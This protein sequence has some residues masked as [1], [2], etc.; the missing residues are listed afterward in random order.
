MPLK[1]KE[2]RG[3]ALRISHIVRGRRAKG[4][5]V[6]YFVDP[7]GRGERRAIPERVVLMRWRKRGN[8]FAG[9]R[10]SSTLW[11]ALPVVLGR[12]AAKWHAH[13]AAAI[14]RKLAA[15][16]NE[17]RDLG[18]QGRP[19]SAVRALLDVLSA[20]LLRTLVKRH[21]SLVDERRSG[22]PDLFLYRRDTEGRTTSPRFVEVKKPGEAVSPDQRDEIALLKRH[23]LPARVLRLIER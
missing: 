11:R 4:R 23:G 10:L 6:T 16:R 14:E 22:V 2:C 18:L 1:T 12:D 20:K 5:R 17:L 8:G 19:A 13:D 7:Q 15:H 3:P 9:I 21:E